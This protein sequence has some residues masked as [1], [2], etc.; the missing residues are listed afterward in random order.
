[1][2]ISEEREAALREVARNEIRNFEVPAAE[3]ILDIYE[4]EVR[5]PREAKRVVELLKEAQIFVEWEE[6]DR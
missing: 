4:G 5:S 2:G 6:E 1:M 3:D